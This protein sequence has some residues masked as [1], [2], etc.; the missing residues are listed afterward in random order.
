MSDTLALHGGTP[1]QPAALEP[2][3]SI[4][5]EENAAVDRVMKSGSL[6]GFVA[7]SDDR[8]YGGPAVRSFEDR[9]ARL[10]G[11]PH[12]V[13]V[14]SASAGLMA[15]VG[16]LG[17]GIGDEVI[18]PAQT[19]SASAAAVLAYNAAPVFADVEDRT[20]GLDPES[21]RARISERTR[22]LM[23]VH[24]YGH[25]ARM[26]ELLAIAREHDLKVIED[27][28]QAPLAT[29]HGRFTGTLGDIGVFS[30]NFHK[31]A[32]CG[33]GGI[34]VTRN[35]ALAERLAMI[36]NHGEVNEALSRVHP[37]IGWNFRLTE[38]NAA[39]AFEQT[40]KMPSLVQRRRDLARTLSTLLAEFSWITVPRV[41][42]G[43]EHTY[44]DFPMQFDLATLGLE[45]AEF[46]AM[47]A[48]EH[49][50][51]TESYRP[52]YR[53]RIYQQKR[54]G[55]REGFPFDESLSKKNADNYRMG[56]CPCAERLFDETCL[57]FEICSYEIGEEHLRRIARMFARIERYCRSRQRHA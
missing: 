1:V 39:I 53:Q 14:S 7:G 5:D 26:H 56:S 57:T 12:A 50:P 9:F 38:L 37:L 13:S 31:H 27:A 40:A 46:M 22:A 29:Y 17:L 18:V 49:L 23:I 10:L 25:P 35:G 3:V 11:V 15:A 51:I 4:G 2:Y 32:N 43:C 28:A 45:K 30:F 34:A 24:L 54:I 20:Y 42:E 21:V 33:E 36:R 41:E 6:S 48:A 19:M 8:F 16:A 47:T 52:V 44:Y 55:A